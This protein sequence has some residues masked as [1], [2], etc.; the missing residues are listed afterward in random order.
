MLS[1]MVT[2]ST[3]AGKIT[4]EKKFPSKCLSFPTAD[5]LMNYRT[6]GIQSKRQGTMEF[7]IFGYLDVK[8]IYLNQMR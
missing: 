3:S 4:L 1:E 7:S 6:A 2:P 8:N 5:L